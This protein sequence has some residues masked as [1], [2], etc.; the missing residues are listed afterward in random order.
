MLLL[1]AFLGTCLVAG[2]ALY[3]PGQ[4]LL[5]LMS[6]DWVFRVHAWYA[7]RIP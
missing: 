1:I 7:R 6:G 5:R 2:A 4:A 3:L